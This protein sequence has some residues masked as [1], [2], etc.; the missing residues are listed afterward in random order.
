VWPSP[1]GVL[2]RSH[3][4]DADGAALGEQQQLPSGTDVDL[5]AAKLRVVVT[6]Q[7]LGKRVGRGDPKTAYLP[8]PSSAQGLQTG[9]DHHRSRQNQERTLAGDG[10]PEHGP[11]FTTRRGTPLEPRNVHRPLDERI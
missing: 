10:W 7:R 11:V 6:V 2:Q 4:E 8:Y 5:D 1:S 9:A 3:D